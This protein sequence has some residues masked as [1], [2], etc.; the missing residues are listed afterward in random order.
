MLNK[1]TR[2]IRFNLFYLGKPPW[3]TGVSPPELTSFLESVPPGQALDVG[4]GTGT[5]LVTLAS[6][7]WDVLGVDIAWLSV[8]KARAK[9]RR[10]DVDGQVKHGDV[11]GKLRLTANFDLV[12]DIGCFH[13]L[14]I[15]ERENYRQRLK[16]WMNPGGTYLL[17]AH[18][19]TTPEDPHGIL[20]EDLDRFSGFLNLQWRQDSD[21]HRPDGGGG[22]PATWARFD[23]GL[24]G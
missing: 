6:Y 21:E 11:I 4:C 24:Q 20:D 18:R 22:R 19:R 5:N 10:A 12:L 15:P 1:I 13:S 14:S 3:D 9:L 2:W 17:Y 8:L 7:G 23:R 16:R